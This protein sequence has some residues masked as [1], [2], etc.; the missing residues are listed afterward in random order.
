MLIDLLIGNYNNILY[1]KVRRHFLKY[2]HS[3]TFSFQVMAAS[4]VINSGTFPLPCGRPNLHN[5]KRNASSL[6]K[7][8]TRLQQQL[9]L[10]LCHTVGLTGCFTALITF[11]I[12]PAIVSNDTP[13][14]NKKEVLKTEVSRLDRPR[15]CL[16][17]SNFS[18]LMA[19]SPSSFENINPLKSSCKDIYHLL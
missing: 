10:P 8:N 9:Q 19:Y 7:A 6:Q 17:L 15:N 14:C 18:S 16:L 4:R 2:F 11:V 1:R 3:P 12:I 13:L 5:I